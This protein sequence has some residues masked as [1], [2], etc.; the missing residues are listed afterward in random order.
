V[1]GSPD[2]DQVAAGPIERSKAAWLN[3]TVLSWMVGGKI[4]GRHHVDLPAVGGL[5]AMTIGPVRTVDQERWKEDPPFGALLM[6]RVTLLC[7]IQRTPSP[8]IAAQ[9]GDIPFEAFRERSRLMGLD[10]LTFASG[11]CVDLLKL[12]ASPNAQSPFGEGLIRSL[13]GHHR[14]EGTMTFY[15][16]FRAGLIGSDWSITEVL[17][18]RLPELWT[19]LLAGGN[20][21]Q[22]RFPLRRWGMSVQR[23]W[24]EDR[25]I[26]LWIGLE[27]L[28]KR[29]DEVRNVPEKIAPRVRDLLGLASKPVNPLRQSYDVRIAVA[30]GRSSYSDRDLW[31]AVDT[32]DK[33]LCDSLKTLIERSDLVD[34][35]G[36]V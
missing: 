13:S 23:Q 8:E 15:Q 27:G 32:A 35:F 24:D 18:A 5:P 21:P 36:K 3:V 29:D 31:A 33:L 20:A 28:F 30:H 10:D 1:N 12:F 4:V 11:Q 17:A 2:V 7:E 16:P 26:D 14:T 22:V 34:V 6:N 19:N 9:Y 25:L